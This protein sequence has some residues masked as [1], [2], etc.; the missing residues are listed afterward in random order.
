MCSEQLVISSDIVAV[1]ARQRRLS[2]HHARVL[3]PKYQAQRPPV[4]LVFGARVFVVILSQKVRNNFAAGFPLYWVGK[5]D[6]NRAFLC[7]CL[8]NAAPCKT[9]MPLPNFI[10]MTHGAIA[11]TTKSLRVQRLIFCSSDPSITQIWCLAGSI[12]LNF[13]PRKQRLTLGLVISLEPACVR[14]NS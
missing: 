1:R 12:T 5:D 4:F 13:P 14:K 7:R 8:T 9:I 2:F 10:P 6:L 3:P 11:P